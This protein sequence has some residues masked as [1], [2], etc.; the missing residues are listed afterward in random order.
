MVDDN[1]AV[2][3]LFVCFLFSICLLWLSKYLPQKILYLVVF[4]CNYSLKI[5]LC[6]LKLSQTVYAWNVKRQDSGTWPW[7]SS[8]WI[9]RKNN[10]LCNDSSRM[11]INYFDLR[12][13]KSVNSQENEK[14]RPK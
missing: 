8:D 9:R 3:Y 2:N 6:V 12:R 7:N 13:C 10:E 1:G 5:F 11:P 4:S 14:M